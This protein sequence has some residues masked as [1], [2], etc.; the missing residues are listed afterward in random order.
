MAEGVKNAGEAAENQ[1]EAVFEARMESSDC[2][3]SSFPS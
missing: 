2:Q 1:A 3:R